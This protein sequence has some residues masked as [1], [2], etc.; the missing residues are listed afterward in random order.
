MKL[1]L[2]VVYEIDDLAHAEQHEVWLERNF[3]NVQPPAFLK[4]G[5]TIELSFS[6]CEACFTVNFFTWSMP[7]NEVAICLDPCIKPKNISQ[8]WEYV[9][10]FLRDDWKVCDGNTTFV[11]I[12][13]LKAKGYGE[14]IIV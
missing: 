11:T 8:F 10:H 12:D 6:E 9:N 1:R 14:E 13:A 3:D 2:T 4:K 5:D 7:E